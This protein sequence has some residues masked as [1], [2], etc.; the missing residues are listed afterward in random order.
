[1]FGHTYLTDLYEFG[2]AGRNYD[3]E[4]RSFPINYR[5]AFDNDTRPV[6]PDQLWL[7][8]MHINFLLLA[9][10]ISRFNAS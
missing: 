7:Y 8:L 4:S 6:T 9:L 3:R 1:M 5:V 2:S 10:Y